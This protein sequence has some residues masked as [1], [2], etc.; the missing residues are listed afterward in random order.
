LRH[1]IDSV[2]NTVGQP[3]AN[4]IIT[5][6]IHSGGLAT[7][8]SDNGVTTKANPTTTSAL[9]SFDFYVANGHYDIVVSGTGISTVTQSDII[10]IDDTS[11]SPLIGTINGSNTIFTTSVQPGTVLKVYRNGIF[12][13]QGGGNDYTLSGNTVTFSVAPLSGDILIAI[14]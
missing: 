5:I 9:G 7:I 8:Y 12:Q 6:N 14:Y 1:Y 13:Q 10:I 4:A 2:L 11:I 3:V